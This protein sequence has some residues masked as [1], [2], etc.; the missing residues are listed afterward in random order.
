MNKSRSLYESVL[1]IIDSNFKLEEE[2]KKV[3]V[4]DELKSLLLEEYE[5]I[6]KENSYNKLGFKKPELRSCI[7]KDSF[8]DEILNLLCD[9]F[10]V[11]IFL[12]N[13]EN[14]TV[15]LVSKTE[16]ENVITVLYHNNIYMPI[17][18][19]YG[20]DPYVLYPQIKNKFD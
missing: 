6:F 12:I 15:K 9:Y 17:V 8:G 18:S 16:V 5:T 1:Y 4:V 14:E 7:E 2:P 10:K 20:S 13:L 19:I 3:M 11:N